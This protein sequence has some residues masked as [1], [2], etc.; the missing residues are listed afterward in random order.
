MAMTTREFIQHLLMNA[1][2]DDPV[3]IEI[4][5]PEERRY[6]WFAPKHVSRIGEG[7]GEFE[8]LI[9]CIPYKGGND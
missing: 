4:R 9:E 8:T 3:N 2:L 6:M 5:I 1:E 7:D